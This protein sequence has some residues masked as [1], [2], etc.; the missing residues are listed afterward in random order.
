MAGLRTINGGLSKWQIW[1]FS[2]KNYFNELNENLIIS[3]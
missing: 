2:G 3:K 1:D